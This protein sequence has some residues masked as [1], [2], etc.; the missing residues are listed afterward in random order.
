MKYLAQTAAAFFVSRA[1]EAQLACPAIVVVLV[2][3]YLLTFKDKPRLYRCFFQLLA[4][5]P[6]SHR[7]SQLIVF[8]AAALPSVPSFIRCLD[9]VLIKSCPTGRSRPAQPS[10]TSN[11]VAPWHHLLLR[12]LDCLPSREGGVGL[13]FSCLAPLSHLSH[14]FSMLFVEHTIGSLTRTLLA[15]FM[16]K[17]R[18]PIKHPATTSQARRTAPPTRTIQE[19]GFLKKAE[20][21]RRVQTATLNLQHEAWNFFFLAHIF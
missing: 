9:S 6:P 11:T 12:G 19:L 7:I 20:G 13:A 8:K 10:Q 21:G 16:R 2:A 14:P 1:R 17:L 5:S 4:T 18:C 3:T 15:K